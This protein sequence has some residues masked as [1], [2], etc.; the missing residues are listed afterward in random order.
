M[1]GSSPLV[2]IIRL[3]GIGDALALTPLLAALQHD[4]IA[5]DVVLR[6]ANAGVFAS[7]AV[8]RV[9]VAEFALR[10]GS[11]QDLAAVESLGRDL[12]GEGYTHV[13][14]ATEDPS[15]Y[16]LARATAAPQRVGFYNGW[17]KPFKSLWTRRFLTQRIYRSAGLDRRAPHECEVLFRL[18][19]SLT[20]EREPAKAAA[21]LR[22]LVLD[23]EPSRDERI[24]VQITDKWERSGMTQ[25]DVIATIAA[26][27]ATTPVRALASRTE[28]VYARSLARDAGIEI[29]VFD[30]IAPWKN[31]IA[32]ARGVVAPDSGAVHVAGMTGTPVVAVFPVSRELRLQ[33]A[34]WAPWAAPYRIVEASARWPQRV[35]SALSE[36]LP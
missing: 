26:I 24:A 34:R 27:S 5:A 25:Q 36:L 17:G 31:A 6:P 8:R 15:G 30:A 7:R 4:G 13:L 12:R 23:D 2:L 14:V 33:T 21:R 18:G 22:P 35:Q 32:S 16:R 28:S 9:V 20:S 19:S 11:A 3:D 1:P 10:S 29:E